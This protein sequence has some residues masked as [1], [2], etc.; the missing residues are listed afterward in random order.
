METH[1]HITP[2]LKRAFDGV[3]PFVVG[4]S[5]LDGTPNITF[6]SKLFYIDDFHVAL[7]HQFM[8]KTWKNLVENPSFMAFVTNPETFGMWKLQLEFIEQKNEGPV[9]EEM[10][11]E[12]LALTTPQNIT[13]SLHSALVCKVLRVEEVYKGI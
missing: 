7:S 4:T 11:M 2:G 10:E 9:F 12:L 3:V 5:S 1:S 13:F 6:M 8:N